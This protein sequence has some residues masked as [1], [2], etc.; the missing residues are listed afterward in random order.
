MIITRKHLRFG[1]GVI[2]SD[3]V[4]YPSFVSF[5][6][7]CFF[8][9]L[10]FVFGLFLFLLHN[11]LEVYCDVG[12]VLTDE[13]SKTEIPSKI[14]QTTEALT[15]F[16]P[17]WNNRSISLSSRIRLMCFLVTSI[18]SQSFKEEY[19]PWK[20]DTVHP[21]QIPHYQRESLCQDPAGNRTA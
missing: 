17:V 6:S 10:F 14:T 21:I 19:K 13:G 1:H 15:R 9:F 12:S 5:F 18:L 7:F 4:R 16:K 8:V 20:Q 11:T 3:L 2:S